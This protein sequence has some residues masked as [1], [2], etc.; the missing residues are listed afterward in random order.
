MKIYA[1]KVKELSEGITELLDKDRAKRI[2]AI[3]RESEKR[4]SVYAGVLLRYAFLQAGHSVNEWENITIKKGEYG[5]PVIELSNGHYFHYSLSHSGEYVAC[6]IGDDEN[7]EVGIDIQQMI[8]DKIQIAKRFF[9]KEEY[10]RICNSNDED[11]DFY[12]MWTAKESYVKLT[13]RGI[14]GG[15]DKCIVDDDYR[16]IIEGA[17]RAQIHLYDCID[18][19]MICVCSN[20]ETFPTDIIIVSEKM[21]V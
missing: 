4:R 14:G 15:I 16:T 10:T 19:Y 13:G 8:P 6:A 12:R 2:E 11:I 17:N 20:D 1:T 3:K 9:S 21:F 5:K 7:S 18:N